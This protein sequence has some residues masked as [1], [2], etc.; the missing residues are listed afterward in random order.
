MFNFPVILKAQ[1]EGGFVVHFPD[2][3]EAITQGEDKKK[4]C[5]T[6]WTHSKRHC[7]STSIPVCHCQ[8]LPR[9]NAG[10]ER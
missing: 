9:Q 4:R 6:L 5:S 1:P 3:P 2:V 8:S 7:P 10:K